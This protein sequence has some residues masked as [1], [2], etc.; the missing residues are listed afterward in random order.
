VYRCEGEQVVALTPAA[1]WRFGDL[2]LDDRRGRLIAVREDHSGSGEP[3]NTLVT[4]DAGQPGAPDVLVSGWDFV[5]SARV[6]PDGRQLAWLAWRHPQMPWD[7][8]ELWAATLD[9]EG[10]LL[11]RRLVAG[12][13]VE[14]IFQPEWAP[15]GTLFF[16]SDRTGWWNLYSARNAGLATPPGAPIEAP[17]TAAAQSPSGPGDVVAELPAA[18]E[19]GLPQW[20]LGT[21]TYAFAGDRRIV[22][23]RAESGVWR[24]GMFERD[25]RRLSDLPTWIE[26]GPAIAATGSDAF[27][28]GGAPA[29]PRT[30]ARV[31]LP[32]GETTVLAREWAGMSDPGD[33]SEPEAFWFGTAGGETAHAFFYPPRN[34]GCRG[35]EGDRPPLIV[36]GHGGP[37]AAA[38]RVLNPRIQFW[39]TRGFAVV[40]VNYRGSTG[41]GRAY[42]DRLYGSWGVAD[43]ED[44]VHAARAL[45]ARGLVDERRMVIRGASSGGFTVLCALAFH[46]VFAAG[47]SYFGVADPVLL[48]SDTHKFEAHSLDT[49]IGPWPQA[50]ALYRERSPFHAADRIASPVL[51]FQ[52]LDDA[53]VPPNQTAAMASALAA[54]GVPAYVKYFEGEGHGFR[55]ATTIAESLTIELAFY[56]EVLGLPRPE[57]ATPVALEGLAPPAGGLSP[58]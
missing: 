6:S 20:G 45:V 14:S 33:V 17:V 50:A 13:P 57:D 38:E 52:G 54:R 48:L 24:L 18:A 9:D 43:V 39:T 53:V 34:R 3:L 47:T 10:G 26:P 31:A 30:I 1:P 5:S 16:V 37:T 55:R 40:D 22:C 32:G 15:D 2:E 7:G 42:R 46:G 35:P 21:R 27:V 58:R 8:T 29:S 49:L 11:D 4:I 25:T 28:C 44:C 19:F 36:I 12:G 23:G 41:F 56:A 51:F